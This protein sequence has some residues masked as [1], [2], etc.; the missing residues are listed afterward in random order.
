VVISGAEDQVCPPELQDE[1]AL[2]IP[3]ARVERLTGCGHMSPL[4]APRRVAG[5]LSE[6]LR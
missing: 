5:I 3:G 6:W 1:L 2:G 4:E